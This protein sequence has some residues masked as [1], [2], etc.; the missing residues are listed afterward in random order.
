MR[1]L[2]TLGYCL[3]LF[4]SAISQKSLHDIPD[5][6][7]I[8]KEQLLMKECDFDKAAEAVVL[9]DVAEVYCL[10]NP[11]ST[12]TPVF[13]AMQRRIRIKI[14][15]NKGVNNA[16][17]HIP[18]YSYGG[19]EKLKN[20]SAQTYNLDEAG[21][22]VITKLEKKLIYEK[23]LNKRVTEE[24]FTLPEVK[25]G[26]VI[27]YK[28][29]IETAGFGSLKN[30]YFQK[31]IPV[32][33]SRYIIDFPEIFEVQ[34]IP[35]SIFPI[36]KDVKKKGDRDIQTFTMIDVPALRDEPYITT[37][38][39]YVQQLQPRIVAVNTPTQ[40]YPLDRQ[41]PTVVKLLMEDEDFGVQLRKEIPRTADLNAQLKKLNNP[42]Q[43][44]M[45]VFYYVQKNMEWNGYDNIWALDGV[46]SAWK[47][48]K[49]T[50]GE[51]N[52]ILIN[53]LKDADINAHAVLVST[54][55]NGR[56]NTLYPSISQFNKVMAYVELNNKMYV[57]D[58]TDKI[59]SP[60]L[61]PLDVMYSEGLVIEKPSTFEWGWK[62]LWNDNQLYRDHIVV[63][64]DINENGE[65]T[66]QA[67]IMSIDYARITRIPILKQ[68]KDKF[69]EKYFSPNAGLKI[70]SFQL[71]NESVDSFPLIQTFNFKQSTASSGIYKY[72]TTNLFTGFE[73]NPFI[74]D[75]RFSDVFF[76]ANQYYTFSGSFVIPNSYVFDGLPKNI[77]MITSDTSIIATRRIDT[78][79]TEL[80]IR[81]T[82]E[83][84]RPVYTAEEYPGFQEFYKKLFELLNEQVVIRKK[85][86][87]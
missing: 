4:S 48:R 23:K 32:K 52:L 77:K 58:A 16:D 22:V 33:F 3:L 27:E 78:T 67:H 10:F 39:D 45:A 79:G 37:E 83:F 2:N 46:K 34:A 63:K 87:P 72:F 36:Q 38:D 7:T 85:A 47:D 82:L 76:G 51:I 62:V 20:I 5:Y 84:K 21:N 42:Y 54:R 57:M 53:L 8:D 12:L 19:E 70:D 66:G 26:S 35:K 6:G 56:V 18:F 49:G 69:I 31:S 13:S 40:R 43:R 80:L 59:S 17:V 11:N 29:T 9:F 28:Y 68:G 86:N 73:K 30:W 25:A 64:A 50:S 44:M 14:L 41:W 24:V 71:Q 75:N 1:Y 55:E 60:E 61:I 15:N 74:S 65:M 81:V